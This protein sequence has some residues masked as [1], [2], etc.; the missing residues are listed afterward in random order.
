MGEINT[1]ILL[2]I[3]YFY[4]LELFAKQ[5]RERL[6]ENDQLKS[7]LKADANRDLKSA[8]ESLLPFR[9]TFTTPDS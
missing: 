3:A 5:K 4:L 8:A 9:R 1:M 7:A 2:A 6:Y